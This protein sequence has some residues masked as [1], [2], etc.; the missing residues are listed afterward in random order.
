MP[1]HAPTQPPPEALA[2]VRRRLR[3]SAWLLAAGVVAGV[4]LTSL[5]VLDVL[6][7]PLLYLFLPAVAMAQLPLLDWE[8]WERIPVYVGSI[9]AILTLGLMSGLLALRLEDVAPAGLTLLSAGAMVGWTVGLTLAGLLVILA[10]RPVEEWLGGGR[11]ELLR[12]LLPETSR[13]RTVFAGLSLSAGVGEE[14]AY[15]GYAFQA[16]QLLGVGPWGAALLSS[17]PFGF[18][19]SYQGPVGVVRT[20]VM[21]F[22][23]AVPVV[24]TGSLLPSMAAHALIDLLVGLLL[25]P[26]LLS[27]RD[28]PDL[29]PPPSGP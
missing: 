23:L 10:F 6:A 25:G 20:G 24:L 1:P 15:R 21:G 22:V 8:K 29:V 27:S 26:R 5:P 14:L 11:P 4:V 16:V 13:E 2:R 3:A 19:H 28:P 12:Q 17:V 9:A 7:L 18:L